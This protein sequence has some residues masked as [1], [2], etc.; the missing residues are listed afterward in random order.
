MKKTPFFLLASHLE[1]SKLLDEL[2][3][4][5]KLKTIQSGALVDKLQKGTFIVVCEGELTHVLLAPVS[6]FDAAVIAR[7]KVGDFFRLFESEFLTKVDKMLGAVQI[8]ATQKTLILVIAPAALN[9]VLKNE[10]SRRPQHV[11]RARSLLEAKPREEGCVR[12]FGS[13]VWCKCFQT[14]C[15][16]SMRSLQ[17]RRPSRSAL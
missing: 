5:S 4:A 2:A 9:S 3:A 13:C 6:Q 17:T 8:R 10:D 15:C 11:R 1:S 12:L 16:S 7:R 14:Q